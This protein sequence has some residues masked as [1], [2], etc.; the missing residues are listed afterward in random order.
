MRSE[1][2]YRQLKAQCQ[3]KARSILDLALVEEPGRSLLA[4]LDWGIQNHVPQAQRDALGAQLFQHCR[5]KLEF[6]CRLT[7]DKRMEIAE[8]IDAEARMLD[9]TVA[10]AENFLERWRQARFLL[11]REGLVPVDPV[12]ECNR[13]VN[14]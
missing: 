9:D 7:P 8:S 4:Q 5:Q 3:A 12:Q 10:E 2:G 14:L 1:A 6:S 13:L 11:V